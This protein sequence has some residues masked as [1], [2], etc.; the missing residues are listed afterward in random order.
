[1]IKQDI[2]NNPKYPNDLHKKLLGAC[3]K[4]YDNIDMIMQE[5]KT[6]NRALVI[7]RDDIYDLHWVLD[8]TN[9]KHPFGLGPSKHYLLILKGKNLDITNEF[10][11]QSHGSDNYLTLMN[12]VIGLYNY[13]E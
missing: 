13:H 10:N 9:F 12:N 6:N 4:I 11:R 8:L 7:F 3:D 5:K 2:S 1:M